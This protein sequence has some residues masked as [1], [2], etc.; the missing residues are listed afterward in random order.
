MT[1][2]TNADLVFDRKTFADQFSAVAACCPTRTTKDVLKNV[3]LS[4]DG[5][6]I[7]LSAS[8]GELHIQ[9]GFCVDST[10]RFKTLLPSSRVLQ[11]VRELTDEKLRLI[12]EPGKATFECGGS[13]F[14]L[15]VEDAANFPLV[16][17]FDSDSYY[18]IDGSDFRMAIKRTAFATDQ[19]STRYALGGVQIEVK[20]S[21]M[22]LAATDSRRLS[23]ITCD[24]TGVN[25]PEW[26]ASSP[27]VPARALK[28][29]EQCG[30]G[31]VKV[32]CKANDISFQCGA[33]S[34]SSQLVQG[35]F[36]DYRKVVPS[37]EAFTRRV[38]VPV[39]PLASIVRQASILST[40]ESRGVDFTFAADSLTATSGKNE[41]G[42]AKA[43]MPIAL[44][45]QPMSITFDGRYVAEVLKVLSGEP[46]IDLSLIASDDRALI[47]VGNFRH[48]IMPLSKD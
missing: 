24:V 12:V 32:A 6:H 46:T 9:S 26:P 10:F 5:D 11:I 22:T 27:V 23:L 42:S 29:V 34:I 44:D 37:N 47:T 20:G 39:G 45:G 31:S 17:A 2:Q 41:L 35:R 19:E 8:D 28:L 48:V 3:L 16:P 30:V 7:T 25:N 43:S 21:S 33:V 18:E 40:E 1:K 15:A 14:T 36:P 38:T 4:A 13:R